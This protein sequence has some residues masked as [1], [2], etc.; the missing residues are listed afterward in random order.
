MKTVKSKMMQK[1]FAM[2]AGYGKLNEKLISEGKSSTFR[3]PHMGDLTEKE[4]HNFL[5]TLKV[6]IEEVGELK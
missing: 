4:L 1:G 3:I 2:D 5:D 6:T